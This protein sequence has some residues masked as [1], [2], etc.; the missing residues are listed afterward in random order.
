MKVVDVKISRKLKGGRAAFSFL[1]ESGLLPCHGITRS[2]VCWGDP[3]KCMHSAP[4]GLLVI[5]L[6][7]SRRIPTPVFRPVDGPGRVL[8]IFLMDFYAS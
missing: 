2:G 3:A 1:G 4:K 7:V 5:S 6:K 8:T